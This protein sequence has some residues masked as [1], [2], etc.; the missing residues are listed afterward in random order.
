[1]WRPLYER[2]NIIQKSR[3]LRG[4]GIETGHESGSP[5]LD[6]G[7][8]HPLDD[9]TGCSRCPLKLLYVHRDTSTFTQL[10]NSD[11]PLK[12]VNIYYN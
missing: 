7:G 5:V 11:S 8:R 6:C 12:C 9:Q 3:K 1:M 2:R 4:L 10:L